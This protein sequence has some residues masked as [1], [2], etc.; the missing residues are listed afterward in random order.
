MQ[1]NFEKH[2]NLVM[3][4]QEI[5]ETKNEW[6]AGCFIPKDAEVSYLTDFLTGMLKEEDNPDLE[7]L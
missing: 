6:K 3:S 1:N 7:T 5:I 4:G 2:L